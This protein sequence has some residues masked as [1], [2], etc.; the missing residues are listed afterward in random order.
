ML[1][2]GKMAEEIRVENPLGFH[3]E[4]PSDVV[5]AA[6]FAEDAESR[7]PP[8]TS[9]RRMARPGHR[10]RHARAFG[11][12]IADAHDLLER[13]DGCLRMAAVRGGHERR[14]A[15]GRADAPAFTVVG[16][17]DSVRALDELGL[18]DK[19]SWVSTGGGASLELLEG[20]ELPGVAAIPAA[21]TVLIAGNWKMFKGP[22]GRAVLPRAREADPTAS[23][24]SSARRTS[25]SR[26][27]RRSPA[28]N[29][30]PA[31]NVHWE[32]E[33]AYTGE[34]SAPMLRELGVYGAIVGH[35][36]R[37]Q[38]FGETDEAR[39]ARARRPRSRPGSA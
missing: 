22:A 29:R 21:E 33:G 9:S 28:P 24:S 18:A 14:R 39:R 3:V 10:P 5:G 35:S 34:I 26:A 32:D 23:T 8:S 13:A 31:Q 11:R 19:I 6:A 25:R 16:G 27:V 36:E 17:G 20:K 12:A 1:V 4:L 37:R 38:F 15:G 2:G 7:S 30:R